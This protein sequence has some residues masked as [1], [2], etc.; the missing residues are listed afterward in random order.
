M[1]M[2]AATVPAPTLRRPKRAR[3]IRVLGAGALVAAGYMD[4]GNWATDVQAGAGHGYA[5]LLVV[6][7][8]SLV[9]MVLQGVAAA[10]GAVTGHD[11]ARWCRERLPR[12]TVVPMWLMCEAAIV[13]CDLAEVVGAAVALRMLLHV[14]LWLGVLL[15][16]LLMV[17][18]IWL[19]QRGRHWLVAGV[20]VLLG[21][22]MVAMGVQ[23]FAAAPRPH[24]M[25][26]G[27][28]PDP[29][30]WRHGDTLW[31]AAG[32][33][34]ATVMP[35]NLYLHSSLTTPVARSPRTQLRAGLRRIA[36]DSAV[37]LGLAMAVNV[38]LL[39]LA[40]AVFHAHGVRQV[41]DLAE[42]SR[43]IDHLLP[44]QWAGM[45]FALA[46]LACA[47]NGMVTATLA[48]QIV[49]EGFLDLRM[50]LPRRAL[51]TRGL[52][53]GPALAGV[54]VFGSH[55]STSLLVGSQVVLSLQL[56]LAVVPLLWLAGDRAVMGGHRMGRVL[57]S[58]SWAIA[59]VLV[60]LNVVLLWQTVAAPASP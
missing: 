52:A 42:A 17:P 19:Q 15:S 41:G 3:G 45:L 48:G 31:L 60:A 28:L 1:D 21:V 37:S 54:L 18:F 43:L 4:P 34:G 5:L 59:A 58:A 55:G 39:V 30:Q 32:I 16:T 49:M 7:L 44:Q 11:L 27:M 12:P 20:M 23:L 57:K 25:L 56:P 22:V 8:A 51:I 13:A 33:V 6:V 9:A 36:L 2:R 10:L 38:A 53:L 24:E 50:S 46:L 29:A 26:A 47:L 40:A 35:H 14:P